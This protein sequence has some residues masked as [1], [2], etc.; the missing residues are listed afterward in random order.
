MGGELI[1]FPDR[2]DPAPVLPG[3]QPGPDDEP[4]AEL[5][6]AIFEGELLEEAAEVSQPAART[7][8]LEVPPWSRTAAEWLPVIPTWLA[9]AEQRRA[10]VRQAGRYVWHRTRFHGL[11]LVFVYP[12]RSALRVPVGAA[13]V[14]G[15]VLR[16]GW[17]HETHAVARAAALAGETGQYATLQRIAS[18]RRVLRV[19]LLAAGALLLAVGYAALRLFA[20]PHVGTLVLAAVL[21][22]LSFAGRRPEAPIVSSA[23]VPRGFDRLTQPMVLRALAAA[24]LGGKAPKPAKSG[25]GGAAAPPEEETAV[26]TP[27]ILRPGCVMDGDGW[28]VRFDLP[29]G[30]TFEHATAR[31]AEIASGLDVAAVQVFLEAD[32]TSARRV[33][34]WVANVDPYAGKARPSPLAKCPQVSV[35]DAHRIGTEPRGQVVRPTLLFNAFLIGAIPRQGKTYLARALAVPA[36]LDPH[37]DV[38]VLDLKGGR[39]WKAVER[40]AVTYRSGDDDEDVA[41]AVAVL[42]RLIGEARERFAAFRR[43]SDEECPE[44]KLTREMAARGWYPHLVQ[45][46]EVQNLLRHEVYGKEALPRLIWLAKTAPAAGFML[47]IAT[48]RPA[49]E[50]IP[51]DLRDNIS[52]RL[53]LKTMDWRSSDTILGASAASIGIESHTLQAGKHA[54]VAVVRGVDNGR[55]GDHQTVRSDLVTAEDFARICAVGRQRRQDAAT[56]RGMA[57]G[58]ADAVELE[59]SLLDDVMAVWPGAEPKVWAET[60]CQRLAELRPALYAGLEPAALTKALARHQVGAVQVFRDGQNRRGYELAAITKARQT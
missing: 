27:V 36:I 35:W 51:A 52:V 26:G 30:K 38:T 43:L 32:P 14:A 49:A 20:P 12:V 18:D 46:D 24:G 31:R 56:L 23:A 10:A 40:V 44:S 45:I 7:T 34:M 57:A 4:G 8:D 17:D 21:A 22:L 11:R 16:Y 13:R 47:S 5:E 39:D 60:V 28:L 6:P 2:P 55:G 29:R 48:Q 50:V 41:Y 54:G 53:A 1:A 33:A 19:K 25:P 58:E 59:V 9:T 42:D 15:A 3:D 37:C